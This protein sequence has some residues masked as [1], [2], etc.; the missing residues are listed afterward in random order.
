MDIRDIH[1]KHI[2]PWA[3]DFDQNVA[4]LFA[5]PFCIFGGSGFVGLWLTHT[6]DL[7]S[8]IFQKDIE[9]YHFNRS[10]ISY[11]TTNKRFKMLNI[12][13][14]ME[15]PSIDFRKENPNIIY[16][17]NNQSGITLDEKI[18]INLKALRGIL[19]SQVISKNT[20]FLY[21]SSG[22]AYHSSDSGNN[23]LN[24]SEYAATKIACEKELSN[25]SRLSNFNFTCVRLFTFYGT[26]LP[27]DSNFFIGN[28]MR[29]AISKEKFKMISTGDST[30]S[31]L[32]GLDMA[33]RMLEL[34]SD[35]KNCTYD[36]G[37]SVALKLKDLAQQIASQYGFS[38]EFGSDFSESI[39]LP[40]IE[41]AENR[42]GVREYFDFHTGF[43][44][45]Y[46]LN[47]F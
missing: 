13:W 27:L 38:I 17:A 23:D 5:Q 22:A 28:L 43:S 15:T 6:L 46:R 14:S 29:S 9:I 30:R 7:I 36:L 2:K 16:L 25:F 47:R 24:Q 26:Q 12:N 37:S 42:F 34:L 1:L 19:D 33:M 4:G 32:Y 10:E 44:I 35:N 8:E 31:Y 3:S 41:S 45:W 21:A 20:K 39:Y 18:Q 11:Q 40:T